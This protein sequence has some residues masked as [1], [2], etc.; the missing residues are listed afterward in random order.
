YL[1]HKS[2]SASKLSSLVF[3]KEFDRPTQLRQNYDVEPLS[4]QI[5]DLGQREQSSA[6]CRGTTCKVG[7]EAASFYPRKHK[8]YQRLWLKWKTLPWAVE[9]ARNDVWCGGVIAELPP[10][11]PPTGPSA[12]G[13]RLSNQSASSMSIGISPMS[14]SS[15]AC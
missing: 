14:I 9:G 10:S 1:L 13:I 2:I 11:V 15:Q 3:L 7:I 4:K 5:T 8:N 6:K 12:E